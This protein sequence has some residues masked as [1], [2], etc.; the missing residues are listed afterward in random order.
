MITKHDLADVC[1][2]FDDLDD[3]D[4]SSFS[5]EDLIEMKGNCDSIA[6]RAQV[7]SD[8]ISRDIREFEED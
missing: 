6:E 8:K 5:R 2:I 1:G 7:A 4:S 3:Q